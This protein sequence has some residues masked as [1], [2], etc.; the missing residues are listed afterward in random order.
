MAHIPKNISE[1]DHS[2]IDESGKGDYFGALAVSGVYLP[3]AKAETVLAWGVRDSKNITDNVIKN[4]A[5]L[6]KENLLHRSIVLV[7]ARYNELYRRF[8]NLN[9]LLAHA[10]A[11][12][13]TQLVAAS[14]CQL[15]ISDK[16]ADAALIPSYL[17]ASCKPQLLQITKGERDLAVACGSILARANFLQSLAQLSAEHGVPLLKGASNRV[18]QQAYQL[19]QQYG[20]DKLTQVAKTHFKMF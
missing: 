11:E 16:F 19:Y 3:R 1:R 17:P 13:I 2:G 8:A 14:N 12:V 7:P 15:V 9:K 10:H 18:K 5:Q 6:I 4:L 20:E